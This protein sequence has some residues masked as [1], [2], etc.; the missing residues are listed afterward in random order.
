[1]SG[2]AM[3]AA[4]AAALASAAAAE[5]LDVERAVEVAL[6]RNPG[7]AALAQAARA[8]AARAEGAG[9][10][11]QDEPEIELAA[12]PRRDGDRDTLDVELGVSQRLGAFG[13]RG[14][15]LAAARAQTAAAEARLAAARVDLAAEVRAAHGR[16]LAA[17][18]LE[19]LAR[20][21]VEVAAAVRAAAVRRFEAGG[22]SRLDQNAAE[23]ELGRARRGVAAAAQRVLE[24]R[25]EL[26]ALLDAEA[27]VPFELAGD[28]SREAPA[29]DAEPLVARA[30][31]SR[32]DLA[33][34]RQDLEAARADERLAGREALPAPAL[35]ARLAREEGASIALG[36][37]SFE[38][39][40]WN[41]NRAARG[42][43]AADVAAAERAV[44]AL[45]R[46]VRREVLLAVAGLA[47]AREALGA[48]DGEAL[49]AAEENVGLATLGFE[50][51]KLGV[52]ELLLVR[53]AALDARR[54]QVEALAEVAAAR[55]ALARA[56]GSVAPVGEGS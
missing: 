3:V 10:P 5:P 50:A 43:A 19:A 24:A 21:E 17:V 54:E 16:A 29:P 37:L 46:R 44:L 4:L 45:E 34:A 55:A 30:L 6:A 56:A 36:T 40:L 7:L 18:R 41:R 28:L 52:A 15:R 8:A 26:R 33:A 39:P 25:D 13:A 27:G 14:A 23:I 2:K 35:G 11:L 12:G 20:E 32:P 49:R 51:G 42:A 48:L 53:R 31:A 1:M 47:A 22:A 38:V 9:T